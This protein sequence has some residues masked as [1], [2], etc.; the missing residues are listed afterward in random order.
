VRILVTGATG[1]IGRYALAELGGRHDLVALT[2]SAPPTEASE[3]ADWIEIDLAQ[4]LDARRL[5]GRVDAIVHLAQSGRYKDFPDGAQDVYAVGLQST[6]SLLEWGR[7]VGAATF[8]LASTGGVYARA[9]RPVHEGDPVEL[10]NLYFGTKYAAEVLTGTYAELLRP[11]VLRPFFPYGETQQRNLVP[12]LAQRIM[13]REE[14]VVVGDPGL[15]I[16]PIHVEDAVRVIEPA[17]VGSVSGV[18]NVAGSDSLA[19]GEL[20]ALLGEAVGIEPLV[21]HQPAPPGGDLV[22][23][24]ERMRLELGVTPRIGIREGI[25]RFVSGLARA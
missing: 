5:P 20:V 22:G 14:I 8:L 15:R 9:P 4:P 2:R 13:R 3:L 1:F 21:S 23:A 6:F 17:L 7:Q 12:T 19:I 11:V 24:T 25:G 16:N 18:I 10:A